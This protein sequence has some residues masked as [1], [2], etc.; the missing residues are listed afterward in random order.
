M[1]SSCSPCRG[2]GK[3]RVI[4]GKILYLLRQGV[5]PGSILA[6][7]FSDKVTRKMLDQNQTLS[8][9]RLLQH[10]HHIIDRVDHF[11]LHRVER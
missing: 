7:T 2:S 4:T 3:T 9:P 8:L 11:Y 1:R 5:Q 6:L 10:H